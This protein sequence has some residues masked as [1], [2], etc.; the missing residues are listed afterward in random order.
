MFVLSLVNNS[1]WFGSDL[2]GSR[3]QKGRRKALIN[4]L[5]EAGRKIIINYVL[6][7]WFWRIVTL[8]GILG[9][10][11]SEVVYQSLL[12]VVLR[13]Y[14]ACSRQHRWQ[15]TQ[16]H[17]PQMFWVIPAGPSPGWHCGDLNSSFQELQLSELYQLTKNGSCISSIWKYL[18]L[19]HVW[20]PNITFIFYKD[21]Q[22]NSKQGL[23]NVGI[24]VTLPI[25][26]C[27]SYRVGLCIYTM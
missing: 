27:H 11:Y 22:N 20:K 21:K 6:S 10:K 14:A 1:C 23:I 7:S 3:D 24:H 15:G 25:N 2:P 4:F 17:Q 9:I 12:L 26:F 16:L 19:L 13:D 18:D 5:H 8:P